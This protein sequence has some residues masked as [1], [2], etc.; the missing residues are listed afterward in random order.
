LSTLSNQELYDLCKALPGANVSGTK[1][2][3]ISRVV[4][5]FANLIVKEI[6]A[7]AEPGERYFEYLV[8][9]ANRDRENLLANK[10]V[11][12]DRQMDS[13]FEDGVR[14]LFEHRLGLRHLPMTGSDHADGCIE[15]RSGDR[16]MRHSLKRVSC[17]LVIVPSVG[18]G[19][20][21]T[22]ARLKIESK[23]DTDVAI[24]TAEDLRWVAENWKHRSTADQLDP[25][26]FNV[27]G[28]L[29]RALLERRMKLLL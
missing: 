12:K 28:V 10:V 25:E 27:T 3:K 24:I 1:D 13:A 29:D 18:D 21:E 6:R 9:L 2:E 8:E 17:F 26:V 14:W 19:V 20:E 15:F 4:D 22:A 23:S 5:Y 16:Y 7:E 11:T